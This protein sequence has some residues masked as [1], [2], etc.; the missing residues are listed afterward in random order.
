MSQ[1]GMLRDF[2]NRREEQNGA[3]AGEGQDDEG[4]GIEL[5]SRDQPEA[6]IDV[7]D[8]PE[9]NDCYLC[10]QEVEPAEQYN[11]RT[12]RELKKKIIKKSFEKS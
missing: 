2:N 3:A 12:N 4:P 8:E 9:V 11:W 6:R 7:A 5:A 1:Q 10:L